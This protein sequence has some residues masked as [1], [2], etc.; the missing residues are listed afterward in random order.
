MMIYITLIIIFA[1]G[2]IMI[3]IACDGSTLGL[4]G[5][6]FSAVAVAAF[7]SDLSYKQGQVDAIKGKVKYKMEINVPEQLKNDTTYMEIKP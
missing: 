5:L 3:F 6:L 1:I 2:V 4:L 7:I